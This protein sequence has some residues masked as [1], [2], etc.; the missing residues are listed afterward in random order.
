MPH[1]KV[2]LLN[3]ISWDFINDKYETVYHTWYHPPLFQNLRFEKLW[4]IQNF[5]RVSFLLPEWY[6]F[7]FTNRLELNQLYIKTQ[8]EI[9][10]NL[11][12]GAKGVEVEVLPPHYRLAHFLKVSPNLLLRSKL[13]ASGV[14]NIRVPTP[15][16]GPG[17]ALGNLPKHYQVNQ[18]LQ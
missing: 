2:F 14:H 3:V 4:S 5:H 13:L 17:H 6:I 12:F 11:A 18:G 10:S 9:G 8:K 15:R 1:Q 7:I 16:C